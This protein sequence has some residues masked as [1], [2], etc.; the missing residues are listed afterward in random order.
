[1]TRRHRSTYFPKNALTP[2][3]N[4]ALGSGVWATCMFLLIGGS[5]HIWGTDLFLK[6]WVD[7]LMLILSLLAYRF[8]GWLLRFLRIWKY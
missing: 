2:S 5:V 6:P 1:M 3:E 4:R 7:I 8:T